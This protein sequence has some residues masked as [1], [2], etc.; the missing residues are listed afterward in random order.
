MSLRNGARGF[1]QAVISKFAPVSRGIQYFSA[2]PLPLNQK[3]NRVSI[4][5]VGIR[6]A[7]A[8]YAV[9]LE[10]NIASSGGNP[11]RISA[12]DTPTPRRNVRRES[13]LPSINPAL[14]E[15]GLKSLL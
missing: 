6:P 5:V 11:I 12:P 13:P 8:A 7:G 4:L 9:P 14:Q 1:R 15:T 3:E 2:M 10:L